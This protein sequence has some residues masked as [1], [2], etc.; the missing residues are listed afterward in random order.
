MSYLHTGLITYIYLFTHVLPMYLSTYLPTYLPSTYTLMSY[1]HTYLLTYNL[2]TYVL[3]T[4]L[5]TY[6]PST[7]LCF[8]YLPTY[9]LTYLSKFYIIKYV[10]LKTWVGRHVYLL[11]YWSSNVDKTFHWN[12]KKHVK[13]IKYHIVLQSGMVVW[14]SKHWLGAKETKVQSPLPTYTMWSMY[15]CVNV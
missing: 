14:W 4:Y 10:H 9:L 15:I 6:L 2:P 12:S 11:I 3:F 1:L 13:R 7:Y 8:I 5:F